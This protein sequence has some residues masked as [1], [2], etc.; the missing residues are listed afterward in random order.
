M[1][2]EADCCDVDLGQVVAA[3]LMTTGPFAPDRST[4]AGRYHREDGM[5]N[6]SVELEGLEGWVALLN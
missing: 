3:S 6:G 5:T 2:T 4:R 1:V